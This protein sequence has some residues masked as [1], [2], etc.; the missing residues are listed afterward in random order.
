MFDVTNK[1]SFENVKLWM[2]I[3][4]EHLQNKKC[5]EIIVGNKIDLEKKIVIDEIQTKN[6]AGKLHLNYFYVS[7]VINVIKLIVIVEKYC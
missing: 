6:L 7:A 2:D 1:E 5:I 4:R 3:V